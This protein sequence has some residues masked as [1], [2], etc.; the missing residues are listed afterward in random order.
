MYLGDW[1]GPLSEGKAMP[2]SCCHPTRD[3][4]EPPT[5]AQCRTAQPTDIYVWQEGC[6]QKLQMKVDQGAKVLIGVGIGIAFIEVNTFK[7]E[8]ENFVLL[9]CIQ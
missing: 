8:E 7:H 1:L 4:A 6:F 3:G 5:E 2:A 9:L